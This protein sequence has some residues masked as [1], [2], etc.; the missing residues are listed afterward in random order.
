M[1]GHLFLFDRIHHC[2]SLHL[3]TPLS[4]LEHSSNQKQHSPSQL[5]ITPLVT[6]HVQQGI[7]QYV[8]G[9]TV[10]FLLQVEFFLQK[11]QELEAARLAEIEAQL[12][13]NLCL[14]VQDVLGSVGIVTDCDVV[15]EDGR[16]DF[17]ELPHY[18]LRG[19]SHQLQL[20]ALNLPL[21]QISVNQ[22][23]A[24][25][26][27][28]GKKLEFLVHIHEPVDQNAPHSSIDIW[29]LLQVVERHG[30]L[31]LLFGQICENDLLLLW[32][33]GGIGLRKNLL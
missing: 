9:K 5:Q 32:G 16:V 15:L 21:G 22:I 10:G 27:G 20:R 25:K 6:L 7:L 26:E 29:L 23:H 33:R 4:P 11:V 28:L 31:A 24:E 8:E 19:D 12:L 3:H 13:E 17:F 30:V 14:H 2:D 1:F 18:H